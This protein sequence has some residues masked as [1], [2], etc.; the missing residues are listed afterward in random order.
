MK[1]YTNLDDLKNYDFNTDYDFVVIGSGPA[2]LV[3]SIEL[4][5]NKDSKILLIEGGLISRNDFNQNN[6]YSGD[7]IGR[8]ARNNPKDHLT[9]DR[10]RMI[11]GSS[12][13]WGGQT[14]KLDKIDFLKRDWIN[15]SGWPIEYNELDTF[16]E[17]SKYYLDIGNFSNNIDLPQDELFN[18]FDKITFQHS[19][20]PMLFKRFSKTILKLKNLDFVFNANLFKLNYENEVVTSIQI[21]SDNKNLKTIKSKKIIFAMGGIE[22]ARQLLLQLPQ[23]LVKNLPIGNYFQGHFS[24]LIG[25]MKMNRNK[26]KK[27]TDNYYELIKNNSSNYKKTTAHSYMLKIDDIDQRK[28]ETLNFSFMF[29]YSQAMIALR[30]LPLALRNYSYFKNRFRSDTRYVINEVSKIIKYY[31]SNNLKHKIYFVMEQEPNFNSYVKLSESLDFF[32]LRKSQINW[33]STEVDYNSF[34]NSLFL[35]QQKFGIKNEE[36]FPKNLFEFWKNA[37]LDTQSHH[38]GTTRM[39]N[40]SIYSVTDKNLKIHDINNLYVAGS[41]VFPTGGVSNPTLTIVAL[42]IRLADHL[43]RIT[44]E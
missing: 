12:N 35:I 11:G 15:Q 7:D 36:M 27:F 18:L 26:I 21:I 29:L 40:N 3:L 22:N 37:P 43:K 39:G 25:D 34:K 2:G 33:Q 1:L 16:Y 8:Y 23:N 30:R 19:N 10:L 14:R 20:T 41:S 9:Y 44:S 17:R 6:L 32:G 38:I 4:A 31:S 42:S 28:N 24:S 5:K 13:I